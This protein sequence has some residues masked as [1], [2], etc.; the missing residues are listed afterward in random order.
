MASASKQLLKLA[1]PLVQKHGFTRQ[2]LALSAL[3]LP[4]PHTEPLSDAAISSLFGQ[5]DDARRTLITA[6]QDNA[7]ERMMTVPAPTVREVLRAR[8]ACNEPVLP[9]LPEAFALLA[10]PTSGLPPLDPRP[11]LR[12]AGKVADD[13]CWI[14]QDAASGASYYTRRTS[15]AAIYAAA[16][17]HQLTSP[18]TAYHFLDS[19]L[20][21]SSKLGTAIEETSMFAQ[22]VL[23]GW[24]GIIKSRGVL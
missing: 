7:R 1:V 3:S 8:L 11:G 21:A 10:S 16:E 12:H 13:A 15:L 4:N 2:A 19:L 9:Y 23:K 6:W 20:D 22:Y 24:A 14:T 18:S 17:L 5:G